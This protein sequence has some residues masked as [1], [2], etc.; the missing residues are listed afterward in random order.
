MRKRTTLFLTT[1]LLALSTAAYSQTSAGTSTAQ[2]TAP[3]AK[4]KTAT[5][6]A[7]SSTTAVNNSVSVFEPPGLEGPDREISRKR[8]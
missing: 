6:S 2:T 1:C 8:R 7:T 3:T 5:K 4:K